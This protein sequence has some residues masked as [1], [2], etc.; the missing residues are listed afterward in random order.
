[1][2]FCYEDKNHFTNTLNRNIGL[3]KTFMFWSLKKEFTYNRS[4]IEFKK[5]QRVLTREEAFSLEDI[6]ILHNHICS[7]EKL[8]KIKDVFVFQSLTGMRHGELCRVNKR[9]INK[10]DCIVLKEEKDSSKPTREIPLI[11]ISKA[12]LEKYDYELPILSNQKHNDYIK[13]VL[14]E[15]GFTHEVEYT[16][17]KGVEQQIF[18]EKFYQRISTH[19]ARRSF[20]TIMRNKGVPDKTTMSITGHTDIKSFN[21]YHQVDNSARI[22]AVKSVFD[23]F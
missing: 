13:D 20:V 6:K 5:P 22:I 3:F 7:S 19:T 2:D 18:V 12:I 9:T 21:M 1:M 4:F 16:R 10:S 23:N 11:S 17:T 14:K 15:A 8:T